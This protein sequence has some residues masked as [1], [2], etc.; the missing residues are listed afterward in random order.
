MKTVIY[1]MRATPVKVSFDKRTN[2]VMFTFGL[3][4]LVGLFIMLEECSPNNIID[5]HIM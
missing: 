5:T 4:E 1:S 2:D 3:I